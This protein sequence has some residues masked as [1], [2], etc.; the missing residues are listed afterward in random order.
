M[1]PR[2][3]LWGYALALEYEGTPVPGQQEMLSAAL[4]QL[5]DG[6][7]RVP[8]VIDLD[9]PIFP[10]TAWRDESEVSE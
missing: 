4:S 3:S 8:D 5:A 9:D 2:F 7:A 10:Y 6:G 1:T